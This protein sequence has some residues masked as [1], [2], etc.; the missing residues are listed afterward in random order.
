[1]ASRREDSRRW[2]EI[3]DAVLPGTLVDGRHTVELGEFHEVLMLPGIGVV[4]VA[5]SA[6][7]AELMPRR[8]R[9]LGRLAALG[10]PFQVPVPLSDAVRVDGVTAAAQTWVPGAPRERGSGGAGELRRQ[11]AALDAVD[12]ST[13]T[14]ELAVPHAYAGGDRWAELLLGEVLPRLPADVR[15]ESFRRVEAAMALP[16]APNGLVHGDLAGA[17]LLWHPD[18]RLSGIID[19][20]LATAFDPAFDA[21]C[22]AWFGWETV[23][24]IVDA[25]TLQ[26]ARTWFATF[27]LEQVTAAL[28]G[29]RSEPDVESASIRAAQWVRRTTR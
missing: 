23:A 18:G 7:A 1:M 11:V 19:W 5:L 25:R 2:Q 17:N 16:A 15:D 13:L 20:D 10:L 8:L 3:V 12:T 22:L 28:L 26:R 24:A 21:A 9:L 6:Q 14:D 27:G 4:R 29:G